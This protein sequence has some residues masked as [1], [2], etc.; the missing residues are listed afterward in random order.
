M[1]LT[2][3]EL[4]Q[5]TLAELPPGADPIATPA[6]AIDLVGNASFGGASHVL[7]TAD[8]LDPSFF[9]LRSG[10]AGEL[11]QKLATYRLTFAVVGDFS[12]TSDSFK[13][14]VSESNRGRHV[15]FVPTREAA[16]AKWAVEGGA[17]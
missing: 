11:L 12:H 4:E 1:E 5:Y 17:D 6:A 7:V 14:L 2:F 15:A 16:L 13:A 9:D 10:L 8:Q 3:T